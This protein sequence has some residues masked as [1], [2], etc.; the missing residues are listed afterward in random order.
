MNRTVTRAM[1]GG[2]VVFGALS[3]SVQAGPLA[4]EEQAFRGKP[5]ISDAAMSDMRGRFISA[6]QILY[7]GVEMYTEWS[8]GASNQVV[9]ARLNIGIDRSVD[10]ANPTV[11]VSSSVQSSGGNSS[12]GGS[13]PSGQ[14]SSGGLDQVQGVSQVVQVTG[15]HNGVTNTL[16]VDVT[17]QRPAM[18]GS[19]DPA[20]AGGNKTLVDTQTG[21]TAQTFVNGNRA[22]VVVSVPMQGRASQSIASALGMQQQAHVAGDGNAVHNQLNMVIQVQP[23]SAAASAHMGN[24]SQTVRGL[25]Q[26]GIN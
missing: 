15:N 1:A 3:M 6:N 25:G 16:G 13:A 21:A 22:G 26:A 24:L 10:S 18:A 5:E 7:F 4:P 19:S 11:Q 17:T 12:N 8:N 2:V 20:L 14:I 9:A 23:N